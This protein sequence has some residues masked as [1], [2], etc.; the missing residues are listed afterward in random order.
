[1]FESLIGSI[2]NM[3]LS[4]N[5]LLWGKLITVNVGETIVELS[6]LV[7]ILIPVGLYFT[8]RTRFLPFRM[9]PE[10]IKCVLEPKSSTNK[11][12]IS[13]LQ[14]LFIATASRVG[15]GNLAGVVAAI[16]FGGPGAIFWM[17]LAALIGASSAFIES[18]LAQ[19]Y[20]EKD[21]LYGGFRGGPAYFMDRMRI[22]TWVKEEDEFVDNIKGTSKYVS[23]DGK[24]YYTRGTRFRLLGVL[25]ALSA[26]RRAS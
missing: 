4:L 13:G 6:L 26:W 20:K 5:G 25:F 1:M 11:D 15:M 3:V 14:A 24:K 12:S 10:M 8:L 7:V 21:P 17:W 9:F 18:T 22:I 16:S 23:A 19:I 2:K